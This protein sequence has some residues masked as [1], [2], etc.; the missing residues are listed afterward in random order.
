MKSI[1]TK[2]IVYFGIFI[3]LISFSL[4]IL[5]LISANNSIVGQAEEGLESLVNEGTKSIE[6]KIEATKQALG[7]L[8]NIEDIQ[9]MDWELQKP[10]LERQLKNTNF[11]ALGIVYPGGKSYYNDGQTSDLGDREYIKKAFE[12]TTNI[13]ELL[14]SRVTNEPVV[15]YAAPIKKNGRVVGVLVGRKDGDALSSITNEISYGKN[16]YAYMINNSGTVISHKD[17]EKVLNQFNPIEEAKKD[18]S[19]KTAST[20]FKKILNE[21]SGVS[22]YTYQGKNLYAGYAPVKDTNWFLV[23]TADEKEVL[24]ALPVLERNIIKLTIITLLISIIITYFIGNSITKPII[25]MIRHSEKIANLNIKE[26]VPENLL[27]KK[28]EVGKMSVA[29]QTITNSFRD[30]IKGISDSSEQVAS[31]SEELTA[32]SQQSSTSIEEVSRTVE[33]IASSVSEQAKSTEEGSTKALY[34]GQAVENDQAHMRNLNEAS[35]KVSVIVEEGLEEIEKLTKISDENKKATEE[36]H[37]GIINTN[38]SANKIGEASTVI[39]SIAEQTNLLALN[40][41]IEAARAGESGQG[42]AVVAEE[43]RKLAEQSTESTKTIDDVVNELQKNSKASVEVMK[44]VSLTLREQ[45]ESVKLSREKYMNIAE[46][47][48]EATNA[49]KKLNVSGREMNKIKD[50]I[51]D[52]LQNLS[53]IAQENSASTQQASASMEEQSASMVEISNASEGLSNLAQDLQ[54]I[55]AKFEV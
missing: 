47:I 39:A 10:V 54:E 28:D 42:F 5:S 49:V 2:L 1:K 25:S 35:Q 32:T 38:D 22:N 26:N 46:A 40:A 33:E 52:T 6:S 45:E 4:S 36:V 37:V 43:I 9:S 15:M 12:G 20:L 11:L 27:K 53:A 30:I 8:T 17:K 31:S 55:I 16:G 7:M 19:L 51:M 21:K 23:I 14:I 13:S 41:A 48:D 44:K 24:S 34:L 3:L 29:L 50:E 18:E